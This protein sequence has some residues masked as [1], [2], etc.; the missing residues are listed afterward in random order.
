MQKSHGIVRGVAGWFLLI[1][2]LW[3]AEPPVSLAVFCS[4]RR[5]DYPLR[6][7]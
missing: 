3:R 2:W 5:L 4:A 6:I 1:Q 7:A